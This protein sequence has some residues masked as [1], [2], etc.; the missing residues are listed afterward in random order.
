MKNLILPLSA[1]LI[2][3]SASC[4]V[5]RVKGE[6]SMGSKALV[7]SFTAIDIDLPLDADINVQE[8]AT[9]SVNLE[10]YNNVLKHIVTK[11]EGNKL[12]IYSDLGP[13]WQLD[14]K[15]VKAKITVSSIAALSLSGAPDADVH[16]NIKGSELKLDISGAS[17]LAIDNMTVDRLETDI[18][19]A[20]KVL[21]DRM[22]VGRFTSDISGAAKMEIRGG[23]AKLASYDISGAAKVVAFPLQTE[24]TIA[25][26]SGAGK[27]EVFAAQKLNASISGAGAMVY[28]GH[29]AVS[30]KLSGAGSV[31]EA[32]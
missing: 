9:P 27:G 3:S 4:Q 2:V 10:G 8:G 12:H 6:G 21:I 24:E 5:N 18:S 14:C 23:T 16:G 19:G 20:S 17:K 11:V 22:A 13:S 30:K 26:I 28:K 7:S 25:S 31:K 15:D 32:D 1:I 29:P